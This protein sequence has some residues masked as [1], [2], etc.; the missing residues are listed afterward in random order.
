MFF[1]LYNKLVI[2]YSSKLYVHLYSIILYISPVVWQSLH[3]QRGTHSQGALPG[4]QSAQWPREYGQLA[5]R[6][7]LRPPPQCKLP[8]QPSGHAAETINDFDN[9]RILLA[10]SVSYM[11]YRARICF[12]VD[13]HSFNFHLSRSSHDSACNLSTVGNQNLFKV[14]FRAINWIYGVCWVGMASHLLLFSVSLE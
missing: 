8:R 6:S 4:L 1:L 12:W 14:A 11:T 9:Q 10:A 3:S 13:S 7:F 5:G 2:L